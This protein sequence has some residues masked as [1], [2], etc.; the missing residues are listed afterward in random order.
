MGTPRSG[1][2]FIASTEALEKVCETRLNRFRFDTAF[3]TE[4]VPILQQQLVVVADVEAGSEHERVI[5]L[6]IFLVNAVDFSLAAIGIEI[7]QPEPPAL[8]DIV[9]QV[10][11][12]AVKRIL[13]LGNGIRA[14]PVVVI[15]AKYR[16]V[17]YQVDV[18]RP[19]TLD[20]AEFVFRAQRL[21]P[22]LSGR[23]LLYSPMGRVR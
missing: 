6:L 1:L 17:P 8:A 21:V 16:N 12:P 4:I 10:N 5:A 3:Y 2:Q 11:F 7:A 18:E 13:L 9:T 19:K 15:V 22:R 23:F 14:I 20:Q